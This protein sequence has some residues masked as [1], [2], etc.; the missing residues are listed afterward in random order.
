MGDEDDGGADLLLELVHQVE[1]LGLDGDVQRGGGLVADEQLGLGDHGHGD[2]HA[3]AH[4]ARERE[5]IGLH[6]A[7]GVGDFYVF[8]GFEALRVGVGLVHMGVVDAQRLHQLVADGEQR[9]KRGHGLLKDHGDVV[10]ADGAELFEGHFE[11]ILA[12]E[13]YLAG[14]IERAALGVEAQYGHAGDGLAAPALPY[15][16]QRFAAL[17]LKRDVAH[18]V[19]GM[20]AVNL[21]I[22]REVIDLKQRFIALFHTS[23]PICP[24]WGRRRR[25]GRRPPG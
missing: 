12:L 15:D 10:A 23:P 19:Q 14:G 16:A 9:V 11:Q 7:L 5:G 20:F 24:S 22:H 2:H 25:A 8:D 13:E 21:E 17:D 3:L 4:A 18:G 1:H 6:D